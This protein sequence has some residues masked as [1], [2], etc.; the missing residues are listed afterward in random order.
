MK[1]TLLTLNL[2]KLGKPFFARLILCLFYF[3]LFISIFA[4]ARVDISISSNKPLELKMYFDN[5]ASEYCFDEQHM[6]KSRLLFSG[7]IGDYG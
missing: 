4:F 7:R 1:Q 3:A 5:H 2:K 6:R